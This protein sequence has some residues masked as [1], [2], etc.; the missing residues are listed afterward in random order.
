VFY[1]VRKILICLHFRLDP[2]LFYQLLNI[3]AKDLKLRKNN[4]H[5]KYR[6]EIIEKYQFV[7]SYNIR[8][9]SNRG[10]TGVE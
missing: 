10:L 2:N 8:N 6:T 1:I 7:L 3:S 4:N 5:N 9:K